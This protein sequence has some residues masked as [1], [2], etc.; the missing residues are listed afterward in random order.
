LI[1]G[2]F[3]G[4]AAACRALTPGSTVPGWLLL[5]WGRLDRGP[6][7]IPE[8]A[9]P[10]KTTAA[11][12]FAY[13]GCINKPKLRQP[14]DVP[15]PTV[16][17][18]GGFGKLYIVKDEQGN[19]AVAKL[20][21]KDPRAERELLIG[22][23]NEAA[24]YRNVV[25][26]LDDGE[27]EDKWVLVMPRAEKS[28]AQHLQ[29]RGGSLDVKEAVAV[30]TDIAMALADI[31]GAIVHRDVKPENILLL[32]GSWSLADF[33]I[34]RYAEAT[35]SADTQKYKLSPRYA[36]PEQWRMEHA[37]AAA[38]VYVDETGSILCDVHRGVRRTP[39]FVRRPAAAPT[40]RTTCRP[41]PS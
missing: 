31:N 14:Q 3:V 19:E 26:V 17:S 30:M 12:A 39:R 36:A 5:P 21:P 37:T 15:V 1:S 8:G 18:R 13:F 29:N 24:K 22:A 11:F 9:G 35:T 10:V 25:P 38:D 6:R 2:F 16:R 40:R 33:G 23:A 32:N 7:V 20:V 4:G 28:L 41:P 34:S 27:Y